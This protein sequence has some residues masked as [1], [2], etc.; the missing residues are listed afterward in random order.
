MRII[1]ANNNLFKTHKA[2]AK[3]HQKNTEPERR[4]DDVE[5]DE[6][7]R[8]RIL[9]PLERGGVVDGGDGGKLHTLWYLA[10]C[11]TNSLCNFF[12]LLV[13]HDFLSGM[14]IAF[15]S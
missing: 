7:D 12:S 8:K 11:S 15:S 9:V 2:H 5:S 14:L 1:K 10:M 4:A 6:E 13:Q 3:N